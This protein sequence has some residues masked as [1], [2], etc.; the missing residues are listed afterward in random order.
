MSFLNPIWLY[1]ISGIIIPIAIHFWNIKEGK[2]FPVG[3]IALLEKSTKKYT[4]TLRINEWLLLILRCLLI[5]LLAMLLAKPVKQQNFNNRRGWILIDNQN[6]GDVY[7]YFKAAID[8]LLNKGFELHQFDEGFERTSLKDALSSKDTVAREMS[9]WKLIKK[10]GNKL[11][12]SFPVYVFTSNRLT[13]FKG[14]RPQVSI[15]VKWFG[16]TPDT[17]TTQLVKA[18]RVS[19]GN[20]RAMLANSSMAG[21]MFSYEDVL[22]DK[23]GN[24]YKVSSNNG[25]SL[26]T[27]NN[28]PPVVVDTAT[29]H[30]S[31]YADKYKQDASY[32]KASLDAIKEFTKQNIQATIFNS[33]ANLPEKI[34]WLFWL[35]NDAIPSN[36]NAENIFRYVEGKTIDESSFISANYIMAEPIAVNKIILADSLKSKPGRQIWKDGFG[37]PLLTNEIDNNI[38]VY[39]FYSRLNPQWNGFVWSDAFPAILLH[40]IFEKE[41]ANINATYVDERMID[42]RQMQP[43]FAADSVNKSVSATE[44]LSTVFWIMVFL[45]FCAERIISFRTKTGAAA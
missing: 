13:N 14:E 9:Y 3:S 1:A 33:I 42:E 37:N 38:S 25:Q 10:A 26:I 31:I 34:N 15:D 27:Y 20:I 7:N 43:A 30:I 19:N 2:A 44:D 4:R 17:V 22:S 40:L 5:I 16:Y 29:L 8:S 35:S 23:I 6:T 45:L 18:W 11:P 12:A 41:I 39:N 36:V 24:E 32:I 28:Q 21:N